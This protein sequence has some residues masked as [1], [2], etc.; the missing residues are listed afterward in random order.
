VHAQALAS[1]VGAVEVECPGA[2]V[3]GLSDR[4]IEG[5]EC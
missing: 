4:D 3:C 5:L 1:G 2:Y